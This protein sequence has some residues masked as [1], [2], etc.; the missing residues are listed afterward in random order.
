MA[1]DLVDNSL[2]WNLS[3][4]ICYE[5]IPTYSMIC[6]TLNLSYVRMSV[7]RIISAVYFCI[8]LNV[9]AARYYPLLHAMV[10]RMTER[11]QNFVKM[12]CSNEKQNKYI[13][14]I[15]S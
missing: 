2:P 12:I 15:E 8:I 1:L 6:E 14:Y 10:K 13:C 4:P 7:V 9:Q 3:E 11:N 5:Y